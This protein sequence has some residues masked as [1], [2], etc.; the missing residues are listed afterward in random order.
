MLCNTTTDFTIEEHLLKPQRV[1]ECGNHAVPHPR[2]RVPKS[3]A[4]WPRPN[5]STDRYGIYV[6]C[7]LCGWYQPRPH[8]LVV[9]GTGNLVFLL[10]SV[11]STS[12]SPPAFFLL[13]IERPPLKKHK[14]VHNQAAIPKT[15]LGHK[16]VTN[17]L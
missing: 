6:I 9:H 12:S 3:P 17:S 10:P 16:W 1:Y 14:F 13:H 4:T 8:V 11:H 5:S 2:L 7:Y 15:V